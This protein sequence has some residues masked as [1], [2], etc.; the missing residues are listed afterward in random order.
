MLESLGP[1]HPEV[2]LLLINGQ[3]ADFD[4]I[5]QPDD[6]IDVY[7]CFSEIIPNHSALLRPPFGIRPR[8]V[9]DTHLGRLSSYL[10]MMGFDTLYRN[11]Y[12]DDELAETSQHEQR[13]LL[14]RDIGLLKR[15]LVVYGRFMRETNPRRQVIEV[16]RCYPLSAAIEPFRH[17]MKCNGLLQW[18]EKETIVD[19]LSYTTVEHYDDFRQCPDCEQVYWKGSHYNKMQSFLAEVMNEV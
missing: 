3:S 14:T 19:R 4:A 8:F 1:P 11:D 5:V 10:R 12:A 7:D 18:V 17:C 9:L 16:L 2:G 15:S 13:I 6:V